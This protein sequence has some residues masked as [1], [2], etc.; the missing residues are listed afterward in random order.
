MEENMRQVFRLL[1]GIA[2]V[3]LCILPV[4][5]IILAYIYIK[6]KLLR[7]IEYRRYF[8]CKGAFQ[9]E[10][11]SLVE[12]ITN[13]SAL[14][15]FRVNVEFLIPTG[16]RVLGMEGDAENGEQGQEM[17]SSFYLRAHTTIRRTYKIVCEKRGYYQLESAGILFAREMVYLDS[18]ANLF[19][20]PLIL[21]V[22]ETNQL[23]L[24]LQNQD[25]SRK[26]LVRDLFSFSG[27][28]DYEKGDSFHSINFKATA[29]YGS[30]KVNNTDF[31]AGKRQMIYVNFQMPTEPEA[32]RAYGYYMEKALSYSAYL[33]DKATIQGYQVGFAANSRMVNGDNFVR[34][35][36]SRGGWNYEEILKEL[37]SIRLTQ[38]NSLASILAFDIK[39]NLNHTEIYVMTI[40]MDERAQEKLDIL[41]QMDNSINIIYLPMVEEGWIDG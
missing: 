11:V 9:G 40:V 32:N 10:E 12:E 18:K 24:F 37:A 22:Q 21:P 27:I 3:I 20:Y 36:M 8:T 7:R 16:L 35:P 30:L 41:E 2:F 33:L 13:R 28:R 38:G 6:R 4:I 31:L 39:E 25:V 15:L 17:V 19:V 29:R 26:P 23:E 1:E 14:P 5:A 34:Y